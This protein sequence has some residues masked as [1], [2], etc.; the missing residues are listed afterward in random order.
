[1]FDFIREV[2]GNILSYFGEVWTNIKTAISTKTQEIVTNTKTKFGEIW[3]YIKSIPAQA[4]QWGKD[5]LNNL[6]QGMKNVFSGIASWFQNNVVDLINKLNPWA[7]HSPSLIDNIRSG[8]QEIGSIYRSMKLPEAV[9]QPALA[10]PQMVQPPQLSPVMATP[11]GGGQRTSETH[12]TIDMDGL[13]AG[14]NI[15]IGTEEQAREV[16]R[17]IFRMAKGRALSEGVSI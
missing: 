3:D 1:M 15:S 14:A 7:R 5:I 4:L 17:E 11:K 2:W 9:F 12:L 13:F 6:W 8:V 10:G 16:A